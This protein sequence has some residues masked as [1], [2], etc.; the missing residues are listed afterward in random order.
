MN[1]AVVTTA[2]VAIP[3]MLRYISDYLGCA[4]SGLGVYAD[5]L[6]VGIDFVRAL[7]GKEGPGD[8][9]G[10]WR[11]RLDSEG[12]LRLDAHELEPSLQSTIADL[13]AHG[14]AGPPAEITRIGLERFKREHAMLYGWQVE[15]VDYDAPCQ[16]DPEFGAA[17]RVIDL[18]GE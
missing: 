10:D 3:A 7:Y 17:E 1:P 15:G 12:R 16:V 4:E 9:G 11:D 6:D 2:S 18:L 5:P 14:D 8:G 13:W